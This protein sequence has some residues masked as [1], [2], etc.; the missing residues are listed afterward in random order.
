MKKYIK[1]SIIS[2][3]L[4]A[5]IFGSVGVLA[6]Q[7]FARDIKYNDTNVESALNDLYSKA[8]KEITFGTAEYSNNNSDNVGNKSTSLNLS[9]GKYIINVIVGIG[10]LNDASLNLANNVTLPLN[11]TNCTTQKIS[12]KEYVYTASGIFYDGQ[13]TFAI[14][15]NTMYYVEV[16]AD[17]ETITYSRTDSPNSIISNII[18][19]QAVPIN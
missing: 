5:I 4:G 12:G 16:T 7:I 11:C 1:V 17:N 9:K 8:N 3:I 10:S 15:S 14:T 6:S 18:A 19:L 13:H 2:F